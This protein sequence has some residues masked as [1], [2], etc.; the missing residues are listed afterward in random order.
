MASFIGLIK[1]LRKKSY[2]MLYRLFLKTG[3]HSCQNCLD[4]KDK[5]TRRK[6][7]NNQIQQYIKRI[8]H[9]DRV[10]LIHGINRL[11]SYLKINS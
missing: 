7:L 4:M 11:A 2:Q 8:I 9:H 5:D 1:Y 6:L 10:V 3:I